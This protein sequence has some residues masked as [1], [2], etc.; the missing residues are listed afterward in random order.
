VLNLA[1]LALLL[2]LSTPA[3]TLAQGAEDATARALTPFAVNIDRA[4]K[5]SWPGYGVYLGQGLVLTAAHV[6]GPSGHGDPIV[7]IAGLSLPARFVKE[8]EFEKTDLTLLRIDVVALPA[9]LGLRLL[10]ICDA[11]PAPN[12]PVIVV[13]PQS[14]AFSRIVPPQYLPAESRRRFTTAIADVATTGNS[15]SGVFD[16]ARLCLIGVISRKI[17]IVTTQGLG[18]DPRRATRDVAKYFIPAAEIRAFLPRE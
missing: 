12:Q 9:A 2:A 4:E 8:G 14:A 13:T 6:V 16:P 18:A 10:P 5:Q 7:H 15:G 11:P 1:R 17:Q 3:S